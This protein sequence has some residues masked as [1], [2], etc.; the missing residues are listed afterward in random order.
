MVDAPKMKLTLADGTELIIEKD[1]KLAKSIGVAADKA[2]EE[3]QSAHVTSGYNKFRKIMGD[4]YM[5]LT[6]EEKLAVAKRTI[7]VTFTSKAISSAGIHQEKMVQIRQR[8]PKS[9]GE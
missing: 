5:T 3:A 1:S 9:N 8:A 6:D 7:V 4:C 2:L